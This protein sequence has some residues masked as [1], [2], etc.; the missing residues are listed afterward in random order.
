VPVLPAPR[1]GDDA[2]PT[3]AGLTDAGLTDAGL[4]EAST[5]EFDVLPEDPADD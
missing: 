5:G 4:V 1:R 3:D 2:D